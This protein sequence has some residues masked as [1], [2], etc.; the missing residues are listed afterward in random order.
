MQISDT[1]DIDIPREAMIMFME[2]LSTQRS[3][4]SSYLQATR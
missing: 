2:K 3:P 4:T 1:Q